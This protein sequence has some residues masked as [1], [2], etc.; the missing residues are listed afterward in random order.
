MSRLFERAQKKTAVTDN[1]EFYHGDEMVGRFVWYNIAEQG[2]NRS[3]DR[4]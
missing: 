4:R 2:D 3:G 1:A